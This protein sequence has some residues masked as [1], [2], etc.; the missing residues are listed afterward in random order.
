MRESVDSMGFK[1]MTE[2]QSRSIPVIKSG[3]DVFGKSQTGTG[4]TLAFAIPALEYIDNSNPNE[5]QILVLCPTRELAIQV[6][7]EVLRLAKFKKNIGI[8]VIYGGVPIER[9]IIKLKRANIAIG[10]PGRIMDHLRRRTL[11]LQNIKM[12]VLD[13]ADEMLSMGFRDDIEKILVDSPPNRQ[14]VLFSATVSEEILKL[15]KKFQNNPMFIEIKGKQE[16]VENIT[17]YYYSVPFSKKQ[18]ALKLLLL[19]HCPKLAVIFCNTKKTVDLVADFL[20]ANC[21]Q[22]VGLHGD[23]QQN[24]R[25]CVMNSFKNGHIKILVATDIMARGID[26]EGIDWV[27]NFDIPQNVEYYV[28]RIGRTGRAGRLG[29]AFTLCSGRIQIQAI[30]KISTI[31]KSN[32]REC[33]LPSMPEIIDKQYKRNIAYIEKKIN[34]NKTGKVEENYEK[35][36]S[37]LEA[38]NFNV[39]EIALASL[40]GLFETKDKL[41]KETKPV[42]L[43]FSDSRF[44]QRRAVLNSKNSKYADKQKISIDFGKANKATHSSIFSLIL[45]HTNLTPKEIGKIDIRENISIIE[46]PRHKAEVV[47]KKIKNSKILK[48]K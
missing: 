21:F 36:L 10:T 28:H 37:D 9:Q 33:F 34:I 8:A 45:N 4:K 20:K 19:Y 11:R 35:M 18:D 15:T 44:S 38:L 5:V 40:E 47:I 2:I 26:V 17:Q 25:T 24:Q 43:S 32:I 16:T 39:R 14:T 7:S 48:Q 13:E 30:I 12:V 22:V 29:E 3:R 6:S 1:E 42:K 23:M 27:I 46:V 31:I 41:L